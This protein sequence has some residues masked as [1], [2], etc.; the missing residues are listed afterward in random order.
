MAC[1][2]DSLVFVCSFLLLSL[3]VRSQ[4]GNSPAETTV[5]KVKCADWEVLCTVCRLLGEPYPSGDVL[6]HREASDSAPFDA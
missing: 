6:A 4:A 3:S 5:P 2:T 1:F